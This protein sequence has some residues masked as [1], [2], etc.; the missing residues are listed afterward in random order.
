M[1]DLRNKVI[2]VAGGARD[3]GRAVSIEVARCGSSVAF[4]YF[5]TGN[6]AEQTRRGVEEFGRKCVSMRVDSTQPEQISS[7]SALVKETF[8]EVDGLVNVIGGLVGRKSMLEMDLEFWNTVLM[9]NLTSPFLMTKCFLP[10]MKDGGSIVNFSSQAA[11]DGG[12]PG[13]LAYSS[14]KGGV[15]T[16]TRGLAK[17]LAPRKIRVNAVAPGM[18]NT[19]FHDTFTKPEVRQRVAS[20]TPLGREG[21]ACEVAKL[22]AYLLSDEASFINGVNVDINGGI[23]FS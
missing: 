3:I 6:E 5:E 10:F 13:S 15:M 2:V 4:C 21:E 22:V 16:F 20:L 19:T 12:G 1:V 9:V 18:I 17:E 8:R 23:L 7:F 11:R 14:A